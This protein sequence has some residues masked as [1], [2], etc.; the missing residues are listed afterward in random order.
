M[1]EPLDFKK[2]ILKPAALLLIRALGDPEP[3]P[4]EY[5]AFRGPGLAFGRLGHFG[6]EHT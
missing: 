5:F 3:R 1:D 4:P 2:S 6:Q